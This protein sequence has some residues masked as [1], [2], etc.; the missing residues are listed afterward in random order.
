MKSV[1]I[2]GCS[3]GGI[4]SALARE[5]QKKGFLVFATAR[6]IS[7]MADLQ[8]IPNIRLLQLDVTSPFDIHSVVKA[9]QDATGGKLDVLVNNSGQQCVVPCLEMNRQDAQRIFGVNFWAVFDLIQAFAPCLMAA[10]GTIVNIS[11]ISGYL[12][13]PFMS[14]YN[15]SKAALTMFG[16]TLRLEML[17]LG[18]QVLTVITG[19]IDTNIMKNGSVPILQ[20]S[21]PY[22]KAQAKIAMLASGTDG[23]KRMKSEE[24]AEKVVHDVLHGAGTGKVWRGASASMTR[25]VSL[26]MPS[27][28]LALPLFFGGR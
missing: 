27:W 17:P 7:K 26:F 24:F 20:P 8:K 2:T 1:L 6:S 25:V 28:I 10:K 3:E 5:F 11:S 13:T 9:V 12:H 16:E 18:I 23:V 4:G 14:V 15:A 22:S 21:L 19:A